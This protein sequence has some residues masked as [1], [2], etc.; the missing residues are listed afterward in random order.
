MSCETT[1][2]ASPHS[3]GDLPE[4]GDRRS[5]Y[6]CAGN[7]P[8]TDAGPIRAGADQPQSQPMIVVP[9]VPIKEVGLGLTR[10]LRNV[11]A[12]DPFERTIAQVAE[13]RVW[14][15]VT[16]GK[17]VQ[18]TVVIVITPGSDYR[19]DPSAELHPACGSNAAPEKS[20]PR[21]RRCA[22]N[23]PRATPWEKGGQWNLVRPER[24][25]PWAQSPPSRMNG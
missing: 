24:A 14:S 8:R 17:Q 2:P 13:Q 3:A 9:V 19:T 10:V 23:Q 21:T 16:S 15:R 20:G 12:F 22:G 7:H 1:L 4:L 5:R 11:F 6:G 25:Q 18:P